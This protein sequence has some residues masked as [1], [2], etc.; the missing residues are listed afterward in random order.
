MQGKWRRRYFETEAEAIAF[1]EQENA[2]ARH[3]NGEVSPRD[4]GTSKAN[5]LT[6]PRLTEW[7]QQPQ[8]SGATRDFSKLV[9]PAYLGPRIER[10]IGDSW[11]M[12]LPFAYDLMRE[13]APNVF[14]EL[15]VKQGESYFAFCQSAAENKINVR[16]YGV[17]SWRGDIQTGELDPRVQAE[18]EA[19]NRRYSSFS[20]LKA[21]LFVEA[22]KDFPDGTID[23][24]H[25]DGTHTYADVKMDFE[26]WLPKLSPRGIILFHDVMLRDHGFGVWKLWDEITR[27]HDSFLFE[28]GCGLGVWKKEPVTTGDPHF[29]HRL[30]SANEPERR[31][32]NE[33]YASGAAALALWHRLQTHSQAGSLEPPLTELPA[34]QAPVISGPLNLQESLEQTRATSLRLSAELGQLNE[35]A[36]H[37][38]TKLSQVSSKL[39]AAES[40][41]REYQ[42]QLELETRRLAALETDVHDLKRDLEQARG[43]ASAL[44]SQ[45]QADRA[46]NEKRVREIEQQRSTTEAELQSARDTLG[47]SR[48]ETAR[49]LGVLEIRTVHAEG[50]AASNAKLQERLADLSR[51]LLGLGAELQQGNSHMPGII[52]SI[53]EDIERIRRPSFWWKAARS[54]GLLRRAPPGAPR[55]ASERRAIAHKLKTSL[56]KIRKAIVAESAPE[57]RAF[58]ISRLL[59]LQRK[60]R[61]VVDSL[62]L[63]PILRF[64]GPTGEVAPWPLRPVNNTVTKSSGAVLFDDA[65]YLGQYVTQRSANRSRCSSVCDDFRCAQLNACEPRS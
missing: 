8:R 2:N 31:G 14:V 11:C 5:G 10:Y 4:N 55:R 24:L 45:Q 54:L 29:I 64:A 36:S 6:S 58:A 41:N 51:R 28:F 56:R 38:G 37:S 39:E 15:G 57:D 33:S 17:D 48:D 52:A 19:Y 16:C 30:F 59:E 27:G 23:L 20:E 1:S 21:M 44:W 40:K 43:E 63:S 12:H 13:F 22:L 9:S 60:A 53:S 61:A 49:L 25:I 47:A 46:Q 42:T 50:F 32:I 35:E 34:D 62:R 7:P 3:G 18:A 26:S 65:W